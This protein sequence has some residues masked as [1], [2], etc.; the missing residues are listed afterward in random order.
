MK[1]NLLKS[2]RNF[3]RLRELKA[4]KFAGPGQ[5]LPPTADPTPDKKAKISNG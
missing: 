3:F 2:Q 5:L 4:A 1:A